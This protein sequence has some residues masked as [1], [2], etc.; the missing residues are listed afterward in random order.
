MIITFHH[1]RVLHSG[2]EHTLNNIRQ[3]YW[4]PRGRANVRKVIW[5]CPLCIRRRAT[6]KP[7]VMADLPSARFDMSGPFTIC[8]LD[9]F[10]PL[11]VRN[12]RKTEKRWGLLITC[13]STRAIH[14]EVAYSLDQDSFLLALRRFICRRGP[15]REIYSDNGTNFVG[16]EREMKAQLNRWNQ[17]ELSAELKQRKIIWHFNPPT[18]SHMGGIW[19]RLVASVKRCL[20]VILEKSVVRDEVLHT[21][22]SEVEYILNGRPLTHVSS[23]PA[24]PE[25]LTPNH[26]LLSRAVITM[27]PCVTTIQDIY[28]KGWKQ[29]QVIAD[30]FWQRWKK[31]Y[32][33]LLIARKKWMDPQ[34]NLKP[35]DVVLLAD[36]NTPRG[37]WPLARVLRTFPGPDGHVRS[38]EIKTSKGTLH[39]PVTKLC[40]LE[41][42]S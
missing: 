20:K 9:Y 35:G 30:H 32:L 23:S 36:D 37:L 24:D 12:L 34:P 33:P 19:E 11:T 31:E 22:F 26:L 27:P 7:Q 10:G 40:L 14:L 4:V 21:A 18:A 3:E 17:A 1:R 39:R 5:R 15:P 25:A 13:L 41:G 8:G 38:V 28:R 16:G 42:H 2:V 6:P 29:A